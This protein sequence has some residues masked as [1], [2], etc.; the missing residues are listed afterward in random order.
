MK[1]IIL[2]LAIV[3]QLGIGQLAAQ[4]RISEPYS[5][6]GTEAITPASVDHGWA[7]EA[8]S[9]QLAAAPIC[10]EGETDDPHMSGKW[11]AFID[12]NN[13]ERWYPLFP[14]PEERPIWF[15]MLTFRPHSWGENIPFNLMVD[16][17]RYGAAEDMQQPELTEADG[18]I[19]NPLYE[20]ENLFCIPNT[21][22]YGST[23]LFNVNLIDGE[24]YLS[25]VVGPASEPQSV[26]EQNAVKTVA[27][28]RCFNMAGQ[29]VQ[30]SAGGVTIVVTTYT[31]GTTSVDKV[32]N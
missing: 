19:L 15:V 21:Y 14:D 22:E 27:G 20:G 30:E 8:M 28:V 1:Q 32:R 23:V 25:V 17:V 18:D 13:E 31:D 10:E 5:R 24:F 6:T 9:T 4:T 7:A 12:K 29:E 2:F 16:G 11:I 26:D 3:A